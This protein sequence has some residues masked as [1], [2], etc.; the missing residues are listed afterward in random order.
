MALWMCHC[1]MLIYCNECIMTPLRSTGN[2]IFCHLGPCW[3]QSV[4]VMY[5]GYV[6]LLTVV[7]CPLPSCFILTACKEEENGSSQMGRWAKGGGKVAKEWIGMQLKDCVAEGIRDLSFSSVKD[8]H[9][10][11]YSYFI[12]SDLIVLAGKQ[13]QPQSWRVMLYSAD[14]LRPLA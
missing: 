12:W 6:M 8:Q 11:W 7:P 5:Y 3:F 9:S 4:F 1:H 14:L 10:R 2:Q 13:A